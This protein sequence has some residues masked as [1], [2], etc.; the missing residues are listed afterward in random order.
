MADGIK[1]ICCPRC[2]GRIEVS[3]LCQYSLNFTVCKNGKLSKRFRKN[4]SGPVDA[5]IAA[6]I[7]GCGVQWEDDEFFID[8]D[9][10]FIDLKYEEEGQ[11][12]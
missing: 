5:S 11:N 12:G 3:I 8:S 7:N 6:C 9:E 4:Y 1:R 10:S 2:G